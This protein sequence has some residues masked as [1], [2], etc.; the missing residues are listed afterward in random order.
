MKTCVSA[1]LELQG[2]NKC[3]DGGEGEVCKTFYLPVPTVSE[4][5]VLHSIDRESNS[6]VTLNTI[7]FLDKQQDG[8]FG[9]GQTFSYSWVYPR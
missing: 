3:F 4:F 8:V 7:C 1:E 9:E 5:Y 2:S 6:T